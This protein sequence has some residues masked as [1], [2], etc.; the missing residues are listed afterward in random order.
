MLLGSVA[1]AY[2]AQLTNLGVPYLV[3]AAVLLVIFVLALM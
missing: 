3:R 1:A 2:L